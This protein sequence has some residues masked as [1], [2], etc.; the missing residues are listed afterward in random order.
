MRITRQAVTAA[1]H[2]RDLRADAARR[3]AS[4]A[5]LADGESFVD[6]CPLCQ[7]IAVDHG[8]LKEG[9]PTTPVVTERRRKRRGLVA[10]LSRV[11]QAPGRAGGRRADPAPALG[12]RAGDGR[13]GRPLQRERVPAHDRRDRQEPRRSRRPRSCRSPGRTARSSSPS[14]GTSPGTSTGS[15]P[16]SGQPVRLAERGHEPRELESALHGA[17][18]RS[19]TPRRP[20]R[21][22]HLAGLASGYSARPAVSVPTIR[23]P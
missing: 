7:E 3:R 18:T 10:A 13:G 14:P 22:G 23:A 1:A 11:A 15:R 17:G 21:A 9:S 5:L 19:L 8:W 16:D 12:A 20:H 2:V 6:V 4:G